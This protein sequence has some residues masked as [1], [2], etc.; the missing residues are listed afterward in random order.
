LKRR[1]TTAPLLT[2]MDNG[3]HKLLESVIQ[4]TL[5]AHGFS[6]SSSQASLVLTDLLSRYMTL[7]AST[8]AKYGQHAG[9]TGITPQDALCALDDL[10]V[11][12]QELEEYCGTEGAELRRYAI[13]SGR[14]VEE[15]NEFKGQ[16]ITR[17]FG[18]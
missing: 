1:L 10:G 12:V 15:L 4:R 2:L 3:S 13:H 9:R 8:C 14:R 18:A 16:L 7:L 17:V 5:H 11:D 6:R